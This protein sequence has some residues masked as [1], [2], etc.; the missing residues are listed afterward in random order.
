MAIFMCHV[1]S[2]IIL[3]SYYVYDYVIIYHSDM[4]ILKIF[5]LII[6]RHPQT[7]CFVVSQHF[8]V[9]RHVGRFKLEIETRLTL[10]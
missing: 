2:K 10:R 4:H 5:I 9:A 3:N 8:S 6:Y 7:D 1:S